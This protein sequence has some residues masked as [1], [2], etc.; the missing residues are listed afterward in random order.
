MKIRKPLDA[1]KRVSLDCS[2][3]S[4]TKQ[5][6][7]RECDINGIMARYEKTGV[8]EHVQ[9]FSGRYGDFLGFE[10]YHEA[11]NKVIAARE[12][13]QS[14]P[15]RVRSR[16]DNDPGRF[17]D[18]ASDPENLDELRELGLA[19]ERPTLAEEGPSPVAADASA[20][21]DAGDASAGS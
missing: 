18:F 9:S 7:S 8:I 21:G 4:R 6:F 17:V 13:F 3:P 10:S 14:L 2:G 20:P 1:R 19:H 15:A 16:F 5:S 12:M 11:C